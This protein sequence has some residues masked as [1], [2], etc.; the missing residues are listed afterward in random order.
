MCY[1]LKDKFGGDTE[2]KVMKIKYMGTAAAEGMRR[3]GFAKLGED[4]EPLH[5]YGSALDGSKTAETG[6]GTHICANVH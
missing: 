5:V 1:T 4:T 6:L 3:A 2:G